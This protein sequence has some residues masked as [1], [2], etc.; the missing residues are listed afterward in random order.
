M[1]KGREGEGA[2]TCWQGKGR[3]GKGR[4]GKGPQG[5]R[6][7][8]FGVLSVVS[9]RFGLGDVDPKASVLRFLDV[10]SFR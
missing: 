9:V 8:V 10:A 6:C 2:G 5:E 3:A 1:R 4:D 7:V